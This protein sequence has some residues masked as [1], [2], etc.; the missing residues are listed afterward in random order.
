M[1][2]YVDPEWAQEQ[3]NLLVAENLGNFSSAFED[4]KGDPKLYNYLMSNLDA[5]ID[6][7]EEKHQEILAALQ[8]KYEAIFIEIDECVSPHIKN[9]QSRAKLEATE[10]D[11]IFKSESRDD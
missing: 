6:L 9:Y 4:V 1:A 10:Q 8:E 11:S 3:I 5:K 2:P 7:C